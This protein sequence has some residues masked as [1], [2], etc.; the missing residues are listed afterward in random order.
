MTQILA[1]A[2]MLCAITSAGYSQTAVVPGQKEPAI[3]SD[4]VPSGS[5]DSKKAEKMGVAPASPLDLREKKKSEDDV[6]IC[7]GC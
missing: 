4:P 3:E 2:M 5:T 7:K 6:K 1:V